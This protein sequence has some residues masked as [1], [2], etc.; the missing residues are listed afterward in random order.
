MQEQ[1]LRRQLQKHSVAII[2]LII[3]I[4][5][6]CYTAW[7]EDTTERNRTLRVA[8]FEVLKN[9]GELQFIVNDSYYGNGT[10]KGNPLLGWGHIAL[11]SDLSE[12]LPKPVPQAVDELVAVWKKDVTKI[13]TDE[14][15]VSQV[16]DQI[17]NC[18]KVVLESIRYL[19]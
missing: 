13:A 8:G 1:T 17:D 5:A 14:E 18:R 19:R 6:L 7:R 2:S 15:A 12:L 16:S 10:M 3:A 11:I 9:L 4:I